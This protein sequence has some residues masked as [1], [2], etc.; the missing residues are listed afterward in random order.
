M[1]DDRFELYD[2]RVEVVAPEGATI[3]CHAKPGDWFEV[4]GEMLHLPPGQ[5]FSMYSLAALLPLLPAKQRATDPN[6]WMSTDAEVA[7][8]DPQLPDALSH[9]APGQAQLPPRR[10]HRGAVARQGEWHRDRRARARATASRASC[11]AAGSS[12][13]AT[14]RSTASARCARSRPSSMPGSTPST[15]PTSTPASRRSTA[16]S[17]RAAARDGKPPL[18]VHT[19]CVPDHDDLARVDAAYIRRIV[20]RS[21]AAPAAWSG[22]TSCS[23][24][25]GTTACRAAW[26]PRWRWPRCSAK[27]RSRHLGGTNFDTPHTAAMLDAGVPLVSMQVQYSLLDR[28]PEARLVPLGR[29]AACSCCATAR[30]P[31]ASSPSAGSARRSPAPSSTQ[32][33]ADQVQADHRRLRR[34]GRVPGAAADRCK[35]I[36][37][38]ARRRHRRGRDALGARPAR[39]RRGDRRRALC[40]SSRRHARGVPPAPRRRRPRAAGAVARPRTPGPQ[41]DTYAL[42]RDKTGRHGRIMKYNLNKT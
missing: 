36:A 37:R 42:E 18:Q 9:H 31:A 35:A 32:P 2:L 5:G 21:L 4:R 10:D 26:T 3:Q 33:L 41:G 7:C 8:P 25:G 17:T 38:Q 15:A 39:R 12:P 19:K 27:G 16:T 20:E 28:R 29:N 6:D 23:S 30:W 22:S 34:L 14:A 13:A 1:A 24:T 40:R 11:A